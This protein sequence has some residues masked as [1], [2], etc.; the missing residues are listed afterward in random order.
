[1]E[2]RH[3]AE[4]RCLFDRLVCRT[5]LADTDAVVREDEVVAQPHQCREAR[6]RLEIVAEDK[7]RRAKRDEK[8]VSRKG[9]AD[10]R[11]RVLA[12]AEV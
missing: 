5:I 1:M 9:V 7:K 10:R 3:G 4:H 11:H 6:A 2:I 12:D 8:P